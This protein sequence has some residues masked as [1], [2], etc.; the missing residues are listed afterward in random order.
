[1]TSVRN[2][3][4]QTFRPIAVMSSTRPV[5]LIVDR[6]AAQR[7]LTAELLESLGHRV[8]FAGSQREG[9]ARLR[10]TL[11]DYA[12]IDLEIPLDDG[13]AARI[14]RGLNLISHAARLPPARRPGL[15]ATTALGRDH[16]LCRLAFHAGANDFLKKPFDRESE[17]PAPCVRRL[18][19]GHPRHRREQ[20]ELFA[21]PE[22]ESIQA[23]RV[24]LLGLEHRRRC[25]LEIDGHRVAL[26][27]QQF[28]LFAYLCALAQQQ[29]GSFVSLRELPGLAGGHR[30]ALAR[31][32]KAFDDQVPGLWARLCERDGNGGVRLRL[33][34]GNI[35]I[36]DGLREDLARLFEPEPPHATRLVHRQLRVQGLP[37]VA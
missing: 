5:A 7:E 4:R 28:H 18:L 33:T 1:M 26:A 6:E 25:E 10:D 17:W 21:A 8:D 13:R 22:L 11:Y 30:Q 37:D 20:L 19:A 34:P 12:L 23:A 36:A 29:P 35:T 3:G 2:D 16:E 32:R 9:E 14:E 24:H 27:R 31:V 15:I